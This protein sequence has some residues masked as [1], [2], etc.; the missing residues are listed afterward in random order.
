M[1]ANGRATNA[2][3][4]E[5]I[6]RKYQSR[7]LAG[8]DLRSADQHLSGCP[9]CRRVLLARMGPIALP[10][11]AMEMPE[12]LHLTYEQ[13]SAYVDGKVAVADKERIEAHAFLCASCRREVAGIRRFDEQLAAQAVTVQAAASPGNSLIDRIA[14]FFAVQGRT[15]EFGL[16]LGAIVAGFFLLY[17]ADRTV[18]DGAPGGSDAARLIHLGANAHPGM[19]LGGFVL[20]TAGIGFIVYSLWRKR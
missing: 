8:E 16:A 19:N 17:Q 18:R 6:L 1:S 2:H 4:D 14:R 15:R 11:Q 13:I 10:P 20:L 12:P 3:L 5:E 7:T 9:G